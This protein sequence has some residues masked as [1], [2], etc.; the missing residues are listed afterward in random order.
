MQNLKERWTKENAVYRRLLSAADERGT[1]ALAEMDQNFER[2]GT[3]YPGREPEP[4][5]QEIDPGT[6]GAVE[7]YEEDQEPEDWPDRTYAI[8]VGF[9]YHPDMGAYPQQPITEIVEALGGSLWGSKFS[10]PNESRGGEIDA[11]L[12]LSVPYR[13]KGYLH[14]LGSQARLDPHEQVANWLGKKINKTL[15]LDV[16]VGPMGDAGER[17]S[18]YERA[19]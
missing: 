17:F 9:P 5:P 1:N 11:E 3:I 15:D 7:E 2:F 12:V 16:Y 13:P 4:D 18:D 19:T 8:I 10:D 14:N 6:T